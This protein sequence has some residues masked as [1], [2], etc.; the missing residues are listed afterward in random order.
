MC[1]ILVEL[2]KFHISLE[3]NILEFNIK[4]IKFSL[5]TNRQI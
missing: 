1:S 5:K 3:G 4:K 2:K